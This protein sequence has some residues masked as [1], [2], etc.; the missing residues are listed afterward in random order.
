EVIEHF[1]DP[2]TEF[3]RLKDLLLPNGRLYCMTYIY[4]DDIDFDS[5]GYKSDFTHAF[6]Y[7]QETFEWIKE[8]FGFSSLNIDGR[9]IELVKSRSDRE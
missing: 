7:Q 1:H 8:N 4:T 6:L 9:L 2:K 5:W 3:N